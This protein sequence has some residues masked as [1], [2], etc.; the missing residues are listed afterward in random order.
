MEGL[1][2]LAHAKGH[3][4]PAEPVLTNEI[5]SKVIQGLE[6]NIASVGV[7]LQVNTLPSVRV[8]KI[9]LTQVF[10]NLIGNAIRYAAKNGDI[11]EVGGEQ[12][13]KQVRF[14]V[15]DQGPGLP[16]NDRKQIFELFYRGRNKEGIKGAGVG[17]A[18]VQKIACSY[19]GKAWVEET[20]GGGCTFWVEVEDVP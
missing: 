14:F 16:E 7:V 19:G 20:D 1:L 12:K 13:G 8:P 6:A 11:I 2:S 4:R 3:E 5:V 9:Y 17:L 10:D 18:I 15:R